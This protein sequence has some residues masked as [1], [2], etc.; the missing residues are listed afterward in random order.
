MCKKAREEIQ[1][2]EFC[3]PQDPPLP[4]EI[5]YV[6]LF[7]VFWKGKEAPNIENFRGSRV[8]WRGGIWG[9]GG[10][11]PKFFMFMP[12]LVWECQSAALTHNCKTQNDIHEESYLLY[13][14]KPLTRVSKRVPGGQGKRGWRGVGRKGS[15]QAPECPKSV[16]QECPGVLER[17]PGHSGDTLRTLFGHSGPRGPKGLKFRDTPRDTPGTLRAGRAR[18]TPV[19]GRGGS[20]QDGVDWERFNVTWEEKSSRSKHGQPGATD[21]KIT[22][23]TPVRIV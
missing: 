17:C 16:S 3:G 11:L 15:L 19:A 22:G 8:P 6:G 7:P 21:S 5:L 4:L 1:H 18:E 13:S 10:V 9:G 14:K 12:F 2:K 23:L 20:Q